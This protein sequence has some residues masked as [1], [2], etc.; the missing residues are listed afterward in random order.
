VASRLVVQ[1]LDVGD[2]GQLKPRARVVE[3]GRL[4]RLLEDGSKV[5][6]GVALATRKGPRSVGEDLSYLVVGSKV[7]ADPKAVARARALL[8]AL[9]TAVIKAGV[10]AVVGELNAFLKRA[11]TSTAARNDLT[12]MF[13]QWVL[14]T[15]P[16]RYLKGS[17]RLHEAF[18]ADLASVAARSAPLSFSDVLTLVAEMQPP[19]SPLADAKL[20]RLRFQA[21]FGTAFAT[22]L[23]TAADVDLKNADLPGLHSAKEI[24]IAWFLIVAGIVSGATEVAALTLALDL[25][26]GYLQFLHEIHLA[27]RD[28]EVTEEEATSVSFAFGFIFLPV[29]PFTLECL[30]KGRIADL[31]RNGFTALQVT[32]LLAVFGAFC[33]SLA[34][35]LRKVLEYQE[36]LKLARE[37]GFSEYTEHDPGQTIVIPLSALVRS[38]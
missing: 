37:T 36:R 29:L 18:V 26:I 16:V 8:K 4:G 35:Q 33:L 15:R 30:P 22:G 6:V 12:L 19:G 2:D 27:E 1:L 38:V 28:D 3:P 7:A 5:L 11:G 23:N 25:A 14:E 10:G 9:Q 17:E 21:M 13:Y 31:A 32:A 24:A 34:R 20:L